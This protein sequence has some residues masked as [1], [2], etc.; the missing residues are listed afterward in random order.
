MTIKELFN[1][2][3]KLKEIVKELGD[4]PIEKE[5]K[6]NLETQINNICEK[7]ASILIN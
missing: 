5:I 2:K 7:I 1:I 6:K 4:T 3:N